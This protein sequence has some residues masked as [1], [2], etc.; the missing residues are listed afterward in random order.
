MKRLLIGFTSILFLVV[1]AAVIVPS[2]MDWNKYKDQIVQ[3]AEDQTGYDLDLAGDL[4]ISLLPSPQAYINNV[5]I[6]SPASKKYE[7]LAELERL[8]L[9]LAFAPLLSGDVQVTSLELVKPTI[10]IENLADGVQSWQTDKIKALM[11]GGKD[12]DKPAPSSRNI[13]FDSVTITDGK[14]AF[15]DAVAGSEQVIENVNL[16]LKA[17]TLSGPFSGQGDVKVMGRNIKFEG[18]T[19]RMEAEDKSVAMNVT[20]SVEPENLDFTFAGVLGFKDA[21]DIQGQTDVSIAD[22]S[23]VVQGGSLKSGPFST[24]G[25]LTYKDGAFEFDNANIVINNQKLT[26]NIKGTAS[27]L[28]AD[29]DINSQSFNLA[30]VLSAQGIPA[31]K[32]L[33]FNGKVQSDASGLR[34]DNFKAKLDDMEA[35]GNLKYVTTGK[36]PLLDADLVINNFIAD[37]FVGKSQPSQAQS[38]EQT[39]ANLNLPLDMDLNLDIKSG[40]YGAYK[41]SGAKTDFSLKGQS[42]NVQSLNVENFAGA[43]VS[44]NGSIG[45]LNTLSDINMKVSVTSDDFAKTMT[46][47]G[48]QNVTLPANVNK[49]N[50][51]VQGKGNKEVMDITAAINAAGGELTLSGN[52]V[53]ALAKEPSLSDMILQV[54]HSNLNEAL[55]LVSPGFGRYDNL[56]K[57]VNFYTKV[58]QTGQVYNLSDIKADLGGISAQGLASIDLSNKVP[59][60]SGDLKLGDVVV[61]GAKA[62]AK[63]GNT[64]WSR[65]AIPSAWMNSVNFDF[66]LAA[67][68]IDYQGWKMSAPNLDFV[69]QDGNLTLNQLNGGLYDGQLHLTGNAKPFSQDGGYNINGTAKLREVSF[70]PL[71]KSFAGDR[72]LQGSGLV[73]LDTNVALG[74]LS[75][76]AMISSMKGDGVMSGENIV[77]EGFDL[78]R[79]ARAMSSEAKPGDTALGLWKTSIKGGQTRFDKMDGQFDIKEGVILINTLNMDGP[80]AFLSTTGKVDLPQFQLATTH[81][82]TLKN[83]EDVPPFKINIS[84]PLNNPTQTLG[85]GLINDYISRKVNRKI[86][87][88]VQDKLGDK[89]NDLLGGPAK[90][91]T[92]VDAPVESGA[93][94]GEQLQQQEPAK[95][96]DPKE[97]AIK[98]LLKGLLQ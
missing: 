70:E 1:A 18:K 38:L 86:Q 80:E 7:T 61:Q 59:K 33:S 10:N 17:D 32:V 68:S 55:N 41:V 45:Q 71:I 96:V 13:A 29:I 82:I 40:S 52:L 53:N 34:M 11:E 30:S 63:S 95:E 14:F 93:E 47:L 72:I 4:K 6:V 89:I 90:T 81:E 56:N 20:G 51:S 5:K 3:L 57:P 21:I 74:G 78:K 76:S 79:F 9:N 97:E 35:S 92:N 28:V 42:L 46:A 75:S 37:N 77:L 2:F 50:I 22:I 98:G 16:S 26:G 58:E 87:D 85:Q 19:G 94:V 54:K 44:A 66:K 31:T 73:D 43:K 48:I 15:Y 49:G 84:G 60:L 88:V 69:L 36:K 64:A 65:Q 23:K 25:I 67:K 62:A 24:K 27:P 91:N 39:L 83:E 8:D 12:A